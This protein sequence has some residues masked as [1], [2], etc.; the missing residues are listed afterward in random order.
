MSDGLTFSCKRK[1]HCQKQ[2]AGRGNR[3]GEARRLFSIIWEIKAA[4]PYFLGRE[5]PA[6]PITDSYRTTLFISMGC[7]TFTL[8]IPQISYEKAPLTTFLIPFASRVLNFNFNP[9]GQ[10][11]SQSHR[12]RGYLHRFRGLRTNEFYAFRTFWVLLFDSCFG[13]KEIVTS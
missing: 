4:S 5:N 9:T 6:R 13:R 10:Y 7:I 2:E 12:E 3:V 8:S 1:A 11:C